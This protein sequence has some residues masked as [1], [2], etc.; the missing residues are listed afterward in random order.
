LDTS[1]VKWL[2]SL[3]RATSVA[4]RQAPSQAIEAPMAMLAAG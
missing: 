1:T 4:V 2:P 3:A